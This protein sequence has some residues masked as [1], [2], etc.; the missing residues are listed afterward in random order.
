MLVELK[1]KTFYGDITF[2]NKKSIIIFSF[3]FDNEECVFISIPESG[4]RDI[5]VY[6]IE[7]SN[8]KMKLYI[9]DSPILG[10]CEVFESMGLYQV[11][12]C[13]V[14]VIAE[15]VVRLYELPNYHVSPFSCGKI[16]E[17]SYY[18]NMLRSNIYDKK[19]TSLKYIYEFNHSEYT[20]IKTILN[21]EYVSTLEKDF[22]K[23]IYVMRMLHKV[24]ISKGQTAHVPTRRSGYSLLTQCREDK[25]QL[26]C[27]GCAIVL[28]DVLL[29]IGIPTKFI[30]CMSCNPYDPE[31]HVTN[32]V[33]IKEFNKWIYLDVATQSFVV[34]K[35]GIPM[36]VWEIHEQ[37]KL[38][39]RL[40]FMIAP[41]IQNVNLKKHSY[42]NYLI[43]NMFC[44][45]SYQKYGPYSD[46][47]KNRNKKYLLL[48]VNHENQYS[49]LN[50]KHFNIN[51]THNPCDF[52]E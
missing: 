46:D 37:L 1:N 48:P 19:S 15:D 10:S 31:C 25:I 2:K 28:N 9:W 38:G 8:R 21:L 49:E 41:N 30:A 34:D 35:N 26:N 45:L 42:E 6:N 51:I 4:Y 47:W 39:N 17:Y 32:S 52:F 3:N 33:Y 20:Q 11:R 13:G 29:S 40:Q 43:K 50:L 5:P 24:L 16:E 44:F 14:T 12:F 18:Q 22:D 36:G 23:A 7:D 27:R